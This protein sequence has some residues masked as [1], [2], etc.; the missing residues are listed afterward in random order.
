LLNRGQNVFDLFFAWVLIL[1]NGGLHN[2]FNQLW[3]VV[4]RE[5]AALVLEAKGLQVLEQQ[6]SH[7]GLRLLHA[8][9]LKQL[10][11]LPHLI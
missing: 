10:L 8:F 5:D 3:V 1:L 6:L 11:A 4:A 9:L 2:L 7:A